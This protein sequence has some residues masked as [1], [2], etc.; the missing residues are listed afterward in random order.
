MK[1]Q[2]TAGKQEKQVDIVGT[3]VELDKGRFIINAG[4]EM[5]SLMDAIN[6]C[7]KKKGKITITLDVAPSGWDEDTGDVLQVQITPT[8]AIVKPKR[9]ANKSTFFVTEELGLQR[10]D[11]AQ[12]KMFEK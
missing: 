5:T 3:L 9:D 8:V 7:Q 10:D 1:T 2:I 11:P 6:R 4:V 12:E